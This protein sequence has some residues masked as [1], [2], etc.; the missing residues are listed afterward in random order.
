VISPR[1]F[2]ASH[3]D[4]VVVPLAGS[5]Q[6]HGLRLDKWREAGLLKPTWFKTLIATLAD[7][8]VEKRLGRLHAA[9]ENKVASVLGALIDAKFATKTI[10]R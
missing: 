2:T 8:L 3:G 1:A 7:S 10:V 5:I 9:D 6:E 4:I